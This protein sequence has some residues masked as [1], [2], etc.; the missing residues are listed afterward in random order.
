MRNS[1]IGRDI[2]CSLMLL[3]FCGL[4]VPR[5]LFGQSAAQSAESQDA[6]Q[7]AMHERNECARYLEDT[8]SPE[9]HHT[10][11]P[12]RPLF[13]E[14]PLGTQVLVPAD[15]FEY[16]D[17]TPVNGEVEVLLTEVT[18][19]P[20]MILNNLPTNSN[21]RMLVSGGVIKIEALADGKRL[22]LAS[23][24]SVLVNFPLGYVED[25]E[26]FK[27]KYDATGTLNWVP[28]AE[29]VG[30]SNQRVS[31]LTAAK[32]NAVPAYLDRGLVNHETFKFVDDN[33][34]VRDYINAM[35]RA[36]YACVGTDAVYLEVKVGDDGRPEGVKT[37]TGK[38]PCYRLAIEE[39]ALTLAFSPAVAGKLFYY[40]LKP[41]APQ[42]YKEGEN[43]FA[44]IL[45]RSDLE[46]DP[47]LKKVL[48]Q[49]MEEENAQNFAKNAFKV[50]ELG[51]VNCDR[52][53]GEEGKRV[54][55]TA[56][57][58]NQ[59]R[60]GHTKAFLV[61]DDLNSAMEGERTTNSEYTFR[62]IPEGLN[63]KVVVIGYSPDAGPSLSV[64][65]V[66]TKAGNVGMMNLE[67]VSDKQ[68]REAMAGL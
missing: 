26:L 39:V 10:Q 11:M 57:V 37:L 27:G 67:A 47:A 56:G 60:E 66:K 25:M 2:F 8:R 30:A 51:L 59:G 34:D 7:P 17:G 3:F 28:M 4:L 18:D 12:H 53:Y 15:A 65:Q 29:S 50:T 32:S 68:L 45:D 42:L 19:K 58:N 61:F 62:N 24:K 23:G 40:E 43:L 14:G 5:G 36:N 21:G 38:N 6:T 31:N 41:S 64:A 55:V 35:L 16:E 44:S 33:T 54:S 1:N 48:T 63:A 13:F 52:F 20:G 46:L 9:R 49:Y 22:R